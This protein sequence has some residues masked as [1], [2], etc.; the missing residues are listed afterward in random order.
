MT[1]TPY[2]N[3]FVAQTPEQ[4]LQSAY[5]NETPVLISVSLS[6]GSY[7][8]GIVLDIKEE[9]YQKSVCMLSSEEQVWFFNVQHL[10]SITVRQPKKMAVALSKGAISRPLN[11][12]KETLTVL[13]LKRWLNAEKT[14]LGS[15]IKEFNIDQLPLDAA[16]NRLNIKD[17]FSALQKAVSQIT[18]DDLGQDA[19]QA[20]DTIVLQQ[21]DAL[22][23][24]IQG[25]T[26]TIS[27]GIDRALPKELS[28]I[29]EEKLLQQL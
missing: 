17:V 21:A 6:N 11:Q 7:I 24:A 12:E 3:A 9:N 25:T 8:E 15:Q 29:L 4:V 27:L 5:K 18:K 13:Q 22:N 20:I 10:V 23:I 19:W 1:N 2:Y 26:L 14:Q 16:N 28:K